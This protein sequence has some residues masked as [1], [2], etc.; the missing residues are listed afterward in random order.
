MRSDLAQL[1]M[2]LTD[3]TYLFSRDPGRTTWLRPS[4]VSQ[5]YARMCARLGRDMDIKEL[6]HYSATELIAAG[7]DVRT[8]AGRLGH[9][10]GGATTLRVY[11]AWRPGSRPARREH[12]LRSPPGAT[13]SPSCPIP[14]GMSELLHATLDDDLNL[15]A[16]LAALHRIEGETDLA[17][18]AKFE[19]FVYVDRV[20]GLGLAREV[21]KC[22]RGGPSRSTGAGDI[23]ARSG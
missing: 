3:D 6:R 10:G 4:S 7:I 2:E 14:A 9:G 20:L 13:E 15:P 16:L 11:S 17:P 19:T 21:G 23:A 18:G 8:V 1:G 22:T 12:R 5:R